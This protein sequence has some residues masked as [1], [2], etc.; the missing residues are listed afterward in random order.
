V[1]A[2]RCE[3]LGCSRFGSRVDELEPTLVRP[4]TVVLGLEEGCE[5]GFLELMIG[6][7]IVLSKVKRLLGF[8]SRMVEVLDLLYVNDY[9]LIAFLASFFESL[10]AFCKC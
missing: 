10:S 7:V 2:G 4:T 1:P 5:D 6:F 8:L 3:E 9:I